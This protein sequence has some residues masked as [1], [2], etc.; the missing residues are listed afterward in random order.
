M[1]AADSVDL[2][3]LEVNILI[4]YYRADRLR[5]NLT[6]SQQLIDC[7]QRNQ[8]LL[9]MVDKLGAVGVD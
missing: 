6:S 7:Q 8:A 5:L 4:P 3:E 1:A 9:D 2:W